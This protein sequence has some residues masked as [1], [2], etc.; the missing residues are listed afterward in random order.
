MWGSRNA[1]LLPADPTHFAEAHKGAR[2]FWGVSSITSRCIRKREVSSAQMDG[3]NGDQPTHDSEATTHDAPAA[4]APPEDGAHLRQLAMDLFASYVQAL[5]T[6]PSN[7]YERERQEVHSGLLAR[8]GREVITALGAPDL[9]CLEHGSH[10]G[11]VLVE[12]RIYI[13]W[14]AQQDPAIYRAFQ[15]YGAA[16]AKL[17]ARIL[18]EVPEEARGSGFADAI[19]NL[20]RLSRNDGVLDHRVV[21]TRDSFAEGKA[22]RTMAEECG[23]LDRYRHTY[24]IAS[25]I[26]H[27]EW[28]SVERHMRWSDA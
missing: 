13:Q 12:V 28:W 26:A 21:D 5:E 2:T 20:E 17:Y 8:A 23:L 22:I 14:M 10:V 7:L 27:S 25:G 1:A 24:Q 18:D 11:R 15:D 6:S 16:K 19:E 4:V 9:W 3:E